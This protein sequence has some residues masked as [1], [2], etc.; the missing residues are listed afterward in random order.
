MGVTLN[1]QPLKISRDN[2]RR[3]NLG[4]SVTVVLFPVIMTEGGIWVTV[5]QSY[6]TE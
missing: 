6:Y 1:Y 4:H 3:W 2:D 5:L